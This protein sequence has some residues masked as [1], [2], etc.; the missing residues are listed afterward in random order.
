VRLLLIVALG[1][2]PLCAFADASKGLRLL[3]E[4]RPREAREEF[5]RSAADGERTS[6]AMLTL[7]LWHG[8]D[9]PPE[10]AKACEQA[11]TPSLANESMA[12]TVLAYCHL[13]GTVVGQ[14]L[15]KARTLA[16][17]SALGGNNEA[18]YVYYLTV[19]ADPALSY[20]VGGKPDKARYD[21]LAARPVEARVAE[22]EAL[23]MLAR[24]AQTGHRDSQIALAAY[25]FDTLGEGNRGKARTLYTQ[26]PGLPEPVVRA[27]DALARAERQIADASPLT[28]KLMFEANK[29]AASAAAG[30]S[31]D[32][33]DVR[34]AST[35]AAGPPQ[36]AVYLPH[37]HPWVQK[38]Y[39]VRGHWEEDWRYDA[40]GKLVV[41]RM[42]FDA[43]GMSG[44]YFRSS[45]PR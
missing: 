28:V 39:L 37:T 33:Q 15:Q 38:S 1:W 26:I 21:V 22:V 40:C 34:L 44:A 27:R 23:D 8:Y 6:Q 7:F 2:A 13:D 18:R 31:P 20:M 11:S 24:A 14:D 36:E 32:C 29:G 35:I 17:T 41:V 3:Q 4:N 42:R 9:R 10:R 12:Q 43:D 16:R 5:E 25:F 19:L 45:A 30:V